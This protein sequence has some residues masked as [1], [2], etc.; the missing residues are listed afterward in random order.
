[1]GTLTRLIKAA[2]GAALLNR[3]IRDAIAA[4]LMRSICWMMRPSTGSMIGALMA[5]LFNATKGSIRPGYIQALI[6]GVL[7]VVLFRSM[8]RSGLALPAILSAVGAFLLS[9][10]RLR[11]G[12]QEHNDRIIDLDEYTVVDEVQ[13]SMK[14]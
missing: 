14:S 6:K 4:A 11:E 1:M 8:N 5:D 12:R 2:V 7:T 9:L 13:Q 10:I 3:A